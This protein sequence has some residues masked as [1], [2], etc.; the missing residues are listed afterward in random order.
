VKIRGHD[1]CGGDLNVA[2]TSIVARRDLW[3]K[4]VAARKSAIKQAALL[5]FDT[6]LLLLSRQ[7]TIPLAERLVSRRLGLQAR[8]HLSP[9]AE[10]G[11][12]VDKP[13][14]LELVR[15][16]MAARAGGGA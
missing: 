2:R 7:L 8:V 13:H 6:L 3:Q 5:G 12:D 4:L 10:L 9:F 1:L 14:Q 11:M 16:D 15:Q